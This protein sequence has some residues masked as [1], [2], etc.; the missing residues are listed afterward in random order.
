MS[1]TPHFAP[2]LEDVVFGD[3]RLTLLDGAA[4]KLVL[5][6]YKIEDLA[7]YARYEEVAH[8]L[9]EGRLPDAAELEGLRRAIAD[10]TRIP[11]PV[12]SQIRQYPPDANP[13][14]VLRT[15][16]SA[17]GLYDPEGDSNAPE[18]NRRK[19]IRLTGQMAA[20]CA[21][22]P[23]LR[24]GLEPISARSDLTLAENF[25]YMLTGA[26]D[27]TA[28][29]AINT[30][31]VILADHAMNPSTFTARVTATT[32]TD[33][34]SAV[35]AGIGALKGPMHGG[36]NAETMRMF[37][38]IGDPANVD[39]WFQREVK[40]KRRRIIGIGH[41]IYKTLD[42]RAAVL[43]QRAEAFA[44]SSGNDKWFEIAAR[45]EALAAADPFFIE[46]SL[47]PNVDYYSAIVLY[48][49]KLDVDMFTPV[50]AMSRIVG[51]TAHIMEQM[52]SSRQL[53][54]EIRYVGPEERE[55]TPV[56]SR[57]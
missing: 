8:L 25:V 42:P 54:P 11:A 21:A 28:C 56:E 44:H 6:G 39:D 41:P 48:I 34:H 33:L 1:T 15:A 31:M 32:G 4:G 38:E 50:F 46:R 24:Q 53:R 7:A 26:A 27:K 12:M 10:E 29:E 20:I 45:L 13:M 40:G 23:R 55:W 30:Y 2:G 51:W 18:A 35:V 17:L 49:I 19:A 52:Q 36:A 9:W 57:E 43:R 3:S 14:A 22:W 47:Y 16:V 5:S 37:L